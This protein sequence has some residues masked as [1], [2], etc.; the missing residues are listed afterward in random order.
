MFF[1]LV[2]AFIVLVIIWIIWQ[3]F[4]KRKYEIDNID[5]HTIRSALASPSVSSTGRSNNMTISLR[6][7]LSLENR[8]QLYKNT[9]ESNGNQATFKGKH[10]VTQTMMNN[11]REGE[12]IEENE[13][14]TNHFES[15]IDVE[16]GDNRV[17]KDDVDDDDDGDDDLSTHSSVE[18]DRDTTTT[19]RT[20]SIC[21][22]H[23]NNDKGKQQQMVNNGTCIICFEEFVHNDVI[24][25][26]Y[27]SSCSH[28]YH[29]ECMVNY[30]ASNAQQK[31]TDTLDITNNPCP[32]CR[33]PNYC[34]TVRREDVLRLLVA[35][36]QQNT[37]DNNS[38]YEND[39]S[40]DGVRTMPITTSTLYPIFHIN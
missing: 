10:I 30:L 17:S 20:K 21:L 5:I 35:E 31:E 15:I 13:K 3:A 18:S 8:I 24:V 29:K 33:R 38:E 4:S 27:D 9:F 40:N 28:I 25:W 36:Q 2:T 12:D 22:D 14:N 11:T 7:R 16:L 6:L 34:G 23:N 19:T 26:S 1:F 32:T 39:N 37:S